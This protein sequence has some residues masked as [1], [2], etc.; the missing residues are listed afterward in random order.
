MLDGGV[1]K[2]GL[3]QVLVEALDR[4]VPE[5]GFDATR[6]WR[7]IC[8]PDLFLSPTPPEPTSVS[9]GFVFSKTEHW[10]QLPRL[11]SESK[12][13]DAMAAFCAVAFLFDFLA[14]YLV[15][16]TQQ[17]IL[18]RPRTMAPYAVRQQREKHSGKRRENEA[19]VDCEPL[20]E[21]RSG[22]RSPFDSA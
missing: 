8:S 11:S 20:Q 7:R 9:A 15:L 1:E 19:G 16:P 5:L 18:S 12:R 6:G 4:V 21:N 17:S 2:F 22:R 10:D 13:E 3:G 14:G